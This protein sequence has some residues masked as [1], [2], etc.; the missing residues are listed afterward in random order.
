MFIK[1]YWVCEGTKIEVYAIKKTKD[2]ISGFCYPMRLTDDVRDMGRWTYHGGNNGKGEFHEKLYGGEIYE[3]FTTKGGEI[4]PFNKF[5][6][7]M[8]WRIPSYSSPFSHKKTT[9]NVKGHPDKADKEI[10]FEI[11]PKYKNRPYIIKIILLD[12]NSNGLIQKCFKLLTEHYHYHIDDH[13]II[14][15]DDQPAIL[16]THLRY[17]ME[18]F[19]C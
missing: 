3:P 8:V 9:I 2:D 18:E 12:K 19:P 5:S 1:V 17:N 6:H 7:N 16:I 4:I 15:D 13:E 10:L 14:K 11:N